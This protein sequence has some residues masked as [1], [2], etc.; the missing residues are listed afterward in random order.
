MHRINSEA[1]R[2]SYHAGRLCFE[3]TQVSLT[4]LLQCGYDDGLA[5]PM[6]GLDGETKLSKAKSHDTDIPWIFSDD[7]ILWNIF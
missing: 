7:N 2:L 3:F 5:S 6:T 4:V 1:C